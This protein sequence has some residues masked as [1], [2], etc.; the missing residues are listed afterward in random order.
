VRRIDLTVFEL[1]TEVVGAKTVSAIMTTAR[2]VMAVSKAVAVFDVV[3]GLPAPVAH[4]AVVFA[5]CMNSPIANGDLSLMAS[6]ALEV[7]SFVHVAVDAV[8]NTAYG[9]S[10]SK[11]VQAL[12]HRQSL[13]LKGLF[14]GPDALGDLASFGMVG[15]EILDFALQHGIVLSLQG[16]IYQVSKLCSLD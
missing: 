4:L 2:T 12:V 9:V 7:G 10:G 5:P 6:L 1:V 14:Q 15:M 3:A 13:G 16:P 8:T 11:T